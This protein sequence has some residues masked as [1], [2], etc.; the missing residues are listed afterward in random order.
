MV[1]EIAL[2]TVPKLEMCN[3]RRHLPSACEQCCNRRNLHDVTVAVS[4]CL[5]INPVFKSNTGV[6]AY[7]RYN[8]SH[9]TYLVTSLTHVLSYIMHIGQ[10]TLFRQH[11]MSIPLS[12]SETNRKRRPA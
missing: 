6:F 5:C 10:L 11:T 8:V 2:S 12:A 4:A 9:A 3:V 1:I 7:C